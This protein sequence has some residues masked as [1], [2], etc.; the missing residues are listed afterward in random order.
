MKNAWRL[1]LIA[2]PIAAG[3]VWGCSGDNGVTFTGAPGDAADEGVVDATSGDDGGGQDGGTATDAGPDTA[4]LACPAYT[5]SDSYCKAVTS[6]CGRC[7]AELPP[8]QLQNIANCELFSQILSANAR[9][10]ASDCVDKAACTDDGGNSRCVLQK[11]SKDTPSV[12]QEKL[13]QDYCDV[14]PGGQAKDACVADF[15]FKDGGTGKGDYIME[16]SDAIVGAIDTNC[17]PLITPD[18][19]D[20]GVS[21]CAT[22]F[23]LCAAVVLNKVAPADACKDGG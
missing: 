16:L 19:G 22:K 9:T 6:F 8:C 18:A 3:F 12:A 4:P 13:A 11:L 20:A 15:F 10:A 14:C 21:A 2:F 17:I 7:A 1:S 23:A 5:G